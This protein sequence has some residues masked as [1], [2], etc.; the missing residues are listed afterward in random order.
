MGSVLAHDLRWFRGHFQFAVIHQTCGFV[1]DTISFKKL[2]KNKTNTNESTMLFK[3]RER[4]TLC[5]WPLE[6]TRRITP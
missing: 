2:I 4:K 6:V 3:E 1:Y 5:W